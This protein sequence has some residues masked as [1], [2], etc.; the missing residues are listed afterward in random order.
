M[1]NDPNSVLVKRVVYGAFAASPTFRLNEVFKKL[2]FSVF[3]Q[4]V[5]NITDLSFTNKS[6]LPTS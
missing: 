1:Q 4:V 3:A 6:A 2:G 5:T